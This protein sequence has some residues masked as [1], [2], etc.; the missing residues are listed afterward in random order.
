[1]KK[2]VKIKNDEM[3]KSRGDRTGTV[4]AGGRVEKRISSEISLAVIFNS[5]HVESFFVGSP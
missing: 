5:E 4:G 2:N 3:N 1:M